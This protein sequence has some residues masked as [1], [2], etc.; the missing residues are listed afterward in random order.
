MV[1]S[2]CEEGDGDDSDTTAATSPEQ[3]MNHM[4]VGDKSLLWVCLISLHMFNDLPRHLFGV[5]EAAPTRLVCKDNFL[6]E[7]STGVV[8]GREVNKL[9]I[10]GLK[11]SAL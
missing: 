10:L 11:K 4:V 7:W 2:L 5:E 6:L 3:V 8:N 9:N 1:S